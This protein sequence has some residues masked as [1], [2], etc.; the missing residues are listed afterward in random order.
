M[1]EALNLDLLYE[2]SVRLIDFRVAP[3]CTPTRGQLMTGLDAVRNRATTVSMARQMPKR[4]LSIMA[5]VFRSGG[6]A[7]GIFGKW[8]LLPPRIKR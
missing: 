1:P 3:M 6:Y 4:E 2:D 5:D 8:H 7:T